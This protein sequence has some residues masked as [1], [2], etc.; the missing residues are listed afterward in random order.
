MGPA[1]Q[2][3]GCGEWGNGL[4][5]GRSRR[6]RAVV[7]VLWVMRKM[8]CPG[9]RSRSGPGCGSEWWVMENALEERRK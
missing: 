1:M 8:V 2:S 9:G 7:R 6:G 3:L 4:P 5:G